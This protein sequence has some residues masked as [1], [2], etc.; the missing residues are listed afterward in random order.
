VSNLEET[1][2]RLR[3][4]SDDIRS[5][6]DSLGGWDEWRDSRDNGKYDAFEEAMSIV[7]DEIRCVEGEIEELEYAKALEQAE[8]R[9]RELNEYRASL[10]DDI[11]G[12]EYAES[13]KKV[14]KELV[15]N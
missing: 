15:D 5:R 4:I 11:E 10:R 7:E 13:L 1:R 6:K 8:E 9:E 12:Q 2:D 3:K 14:E